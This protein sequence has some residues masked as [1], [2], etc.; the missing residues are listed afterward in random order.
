MSIGNRW[1]WLDRRCAAGRG[2]DTAGFS[3]RVLISDV[4]VRGVAIVVDAGDLRIA[5]LKELPDED[6]LR[7]VLCTGESSSIIGAAGG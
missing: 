6:K 4:D 5:A 1:H 7:S 3:S 2:D